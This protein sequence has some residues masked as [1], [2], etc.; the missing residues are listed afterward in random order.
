MAERKLFKD[1]VGPTSVGVLADALE[2]V[3][4]GFERGPFERRCLDGLDALELK[5]RIAHVIEA[6]HELLPPDFLEAA[7]L[8]ERLG[9]QWDASAMAE[10]T[11][12][13]A[14]W[15]LIDYVGAYGLSHFDLAMDTCRLLTPLGSAEMAVRPF[16]RADPVRAMRH[17]SAWISDPDPHV[18]RLASEGCRPRLPWGGHIKVFRE[19]PSPV[20]ALL[21]PLKDDPSEYVRR[22]VAN[23]LNDISKDHPERALTVCRAWLSGP[24][25]SRERTRLVRHALRTLIKAGHPAVFALLGYTD[26]PKV[27]V[28]GL[29]VSPATVALGGAVTFTATLRSLADTEQRVVVDYAIHHVKKSG[30]TTPK[31]FKLTERALAP[32]ATSAIERRHALKPISTR[33]YYA[34]EHAVELLINGVGQGR[35]WFGL[36]V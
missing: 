22:S 2:R 31:V 21:E 15:P 1:H 13:F 30:K 6:L 8:L 26:D 34:G 3:V 33:T 23:N 18:R 36:V 24:A 28:E 29:T 19:D 20:V 35:V 12:F 7:P 32:G 14:S 16:L 9:A 17:M 11:R 10:G 25:V 27:V 5:E 4:P